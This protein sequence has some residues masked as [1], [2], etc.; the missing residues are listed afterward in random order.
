[1]LS[2][3]I[4]SSIIVAL[5]STAMYGS[6]F[7]VQAEKDRKALIKYFEDKFADPDK[8][9][10]R[11]FPYS[12]DDELKNNMPKNVKFEDFAIGNYAWS[13]Q[14][15]EQYDEINE[16]PPYEDYID[17]GEEIYT[18]SKVLQGCFP[19][20][21]IGGDYPYFSDKRGEIVTLGVAINECLTAG[22]QKPFNM[23]KGK[24]AHLQAYM[25]FQT[26]EAGKKTNIKISS[27][28]ASDA[29]ERGKEYYYSQKGYLKLS[30]ASCHVQGA[31]ARVRNENLSQL[32]G[33]TTHWPAFRLK[34]GGKNVN[35][36]GLGTVERRVQGCIKDE[37][38]VPPSVTSNEMKE[39]LYFMTYMSNDLNVDGPDIRK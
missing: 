12:T 24:M 37:G 7:N 3:I 15:K 16:M 17:I 39:L 18:S 8:N 25:V 31:G 28:A 5:A 22:K 20:V 23:K 27:Q 33:H 29:Y 35:G 10:N 2:K 38:Q 36:D 6:S 32:L 19:D 1:M 14:G 11:F 4:K 30:C 26:R 9:R 21:T 34:W 13:I